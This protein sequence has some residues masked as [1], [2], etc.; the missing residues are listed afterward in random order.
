MEEGQPSAAAD[1]GAGTSH[2]FP[3]SSTLKNLGKN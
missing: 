2:Q 1:S 3:S